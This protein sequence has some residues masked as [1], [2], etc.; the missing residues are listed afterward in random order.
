MQ[1]PGDPEQAALG[2]MYCLCDTAGDWFSPAVTVTCGRLVQSR[3]HAVLLEGIFQHY[4]LLCHCGRLIQSCRHAFW[5]EGIFQL[6]RLLWPS[7]ETDPVLPFVTCGRLIQSRRHAVLL[8][9]FFQHYRLFGPRG[10]LTQSCH[11]RNLR[12]TDPV[13]PFVTCGRLI[14]SCRHAVV[15]E[16]IFQ[17]DR[18]LCLLE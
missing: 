13:L 16:V 4:R 12:E 11:C 9:G 2:Q 6:D 1:I 10:R 14:Q 15:L 5:L 18:Q 7:R 3:R 8:E 17:L